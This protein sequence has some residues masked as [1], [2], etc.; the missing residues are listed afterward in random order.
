MPSRPTPR[1]RPR[2]AAFPVLASL[3]AWCALAAAA[4][5]APQRHATLPAVSGD[6]RWVAFTRADD[7]GGVELHVMP[8]AGGE[9]RRVL[10][11]RE[12]YVV[13]GWLGRD[14]L[15]AYRTLGDSVWVERA[16]GP[17]GTP[18]PWFG[19]RGK[20]LRLS[21]DGS[22]AIWA[23]GSWTRNR[24]MAGRVGGGHH[25][26]GDTSAAWYNMAWSPD[27]RRVAAT[28]SDPE[29]GP[30]VWVLGPGPDSARALT[31]FAA[32]QGRPQWPTWSP[33]GRRIAFQVD[34]P[35]REHAHAVRGEIWVADADGGPARALLAH[36]GAWLDETPS[37]SP[38][39]R[40]IV[41]QSTRSGRFELWSVRPDGKGLR[42]LTR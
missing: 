14:T 33:D 28:R 4:H 23:V 18:A 35:D 11:T 3:A 5:A 25:A 13:G 17:R 6:G 34:F 27:G 8:I 15:L 2:P 7:S 37:W 31:A 38:D 16:P 30:Q 40:V 20:G 39:G 10:E 41:F 26:V 24:L 12:G 22:S 32:A 42:Q 1:W 21:A 36:A 19:V 29:G 9:S